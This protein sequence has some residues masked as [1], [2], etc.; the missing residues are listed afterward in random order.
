M[1]FVY[2][3]VPVWIDLHNAFEQSSALQDITYNIFM[4]SSLM[5]QMLYNVLVMT[6]ILETVLV[7]L[8]SFESVN[9]IYLSA[10]FRCSDA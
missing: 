1:L 2:F 6:I 3:D 7:E 4:E 9:I 5:C 10:F 8:I